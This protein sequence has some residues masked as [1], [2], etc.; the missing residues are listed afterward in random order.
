MLTVRCSHL[1]DFQPST[2]GGLNNE[3]VFSPRLDNQFSS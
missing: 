2:L 3:F 1:Y